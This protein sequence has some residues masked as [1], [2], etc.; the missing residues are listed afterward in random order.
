MEKI[1]TD[2]LKSAGKGIKSDNKLANIYGR[3]IVS[4][5]SSMFHRQHYSYD[6]IVSEAKAY[7]LDASPEELEVIV[8]QTK[9]AYFKYKCTAREYFVFDLKNKSKKEIKELLFDI[10]KIVLITLVNDRKDLK[11]L[12]AKEKAYLKLNEYYERDMIF[13]KNKGDISLE[14]FAEFVKK[15]SGFISKPS[16]MSLARGI[17]VYKDIK[18]P[19]NDDIKKMYNE[20]FENTP[21]IIEEL[22]HNSD[23]YAKFHPQSLNIVR[24]VCFRQKGEMKLYRT[25]LSLGCGDKDFAN[26]AAGAIAI[27]IDY[28]TGVTSDIGY[29]EALKTYEVH[30]DSGLPLKNIKLE[31]WDE[32]VELVKELGKILPSLNYVGWDLACTPKGW[33]IVEGNG[34]A[35]QLLYQ[36]MGGKSIRSEFMKY[37]KNI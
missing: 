37:Y 23:F 18:A 25:Y 22:I 24:A 14:Q 1:Y 4:V 35:G 28:N 19:S 12:N 29:T 16:N 5:L 32:L 13:A 7:N 11:L 2:I 20:V 36:L 21:V 8:K 30:P 33:V 3:I 31:Q 9:K 27:P 26:G 17:K 15:H 34:N 6:E 10:E